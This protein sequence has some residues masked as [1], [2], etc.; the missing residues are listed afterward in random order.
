MTLGTSSQPSRLR[1]VRLK[2]FVRLTEEIPF[3]ISAKENSTQSSLSCELRK[4]P[5]LQSFWTA[6]MQAV[7]CV[8]STE[9]TPTLSALF[10]PIRTGDHD[11]GDAPDLMRMFEAADSNPRRSPNVPN[12][13]SESWMPLPS[14]CQDFQYAEESNFEDGSNETDVGMRRTWPVTRLSPRQGRFTLAL[15]KILESEMARKATYESVITSIGRL[16]RMQAPVAVGSRKHAQLWFCKEECCAPGNFFE[17]KQITICNE[18]F[19]DCLPCTVI[20]RC[21]LYLLVINPYST[22]Q[23]SVNYYAFLFTV[24]RINSSI[25]FGDRDCSLVQVQSLELHAHV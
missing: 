15:I 9:V 11:A 2:R 24:T 5:I 12:I 22:Q 8:L 14:Y 10:P 20:N 3:P 13:F 7:R 19:L 23:F 6:V 17:S 25:L 18:C 16:G 21:Y 1:L 4:V